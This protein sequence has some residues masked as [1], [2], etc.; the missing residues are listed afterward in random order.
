VAESPIFERHGEVIDLGACLVGKNLNLLV[1]RGF[2][3]LDVLAE[4][5]A[6]D[7]YDQVDNKTGTQRDL[8][9]KHAEECF[10]YAIESLASAPED[11]PHAFPE[12]ILNARDTAVIEVF[13]L[14]DESSLYDITSYSDE[15]E[16]GEKFVGARVLARD[17][18]WP[19]PSKSP[20]ISRVD[21]N[22]RLYQT[23]KVL[24][25]A[26]T[27]GNGDLDL[28]FPI[29]PF[30]LM[31]ALDDLQEAHL[32]RDINGEHQGMETAH[33]DTIVY[34]I[35]DQSS[36][37][38]DPKLRALWLAHKLTEPGRA[39]DGMVFLGGSKTG[40]K[41]SEG[42][43]PPIKINALKS[44]ITAQ[45]KAAP[46]VS[47]ALSD[48]PEKLLELLDRFWRAVKETFPEAWQNK[49]DYVLLQ[50]IGLG[51]FAKFGGIV[52]ERSVE[53]G[54]V[55]YDDL[56][57]HLRPLQSAVSLKRDDYP[58]IAGAGG[59]QYV[60]ERLIAASDADAVKK[61]MLLKA[62]GGEDGATTSLDEE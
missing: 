41:R 34:R 38:S 27:N 32:F 2:A 15:A 12:I 53:S 58:G 39:F 1:L 16:V 21:G 25:D 36:M 43:I 17:L 18:E 5:S 59:A 46:S 35:T 30:T 6:P 62:L 28:E 40:L 14:D 23:D 49:K 11:D 3:P 54:A 51:A 9:P 4:I 45:L 33:L 57:N 52:L 29:V 31:L 56:L 48:S 47:T 24:A 22:H 13:N 19:K 10:D 37:K 55:S 60:A 8:K 7:V 42:Q 61:E 44:T 26:W 20:Q 50:A